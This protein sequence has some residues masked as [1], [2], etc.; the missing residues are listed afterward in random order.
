M[1]ER[2]VEYERMGGVM[3]ERK[4]GQRRWRQWIWGGM[5]QDEGRDEALK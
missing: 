5:T 3:V 4:E 1:A 2:A